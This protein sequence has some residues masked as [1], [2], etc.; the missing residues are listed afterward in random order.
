MDRKPLSDARASA[1]GILAVSFVITVISFFS[2]YWLVAD[3]RY[4]G[5]EFDKLGLWTVC[6]RS[7]RGP[8][9]LEYTKYYS[10]CRWIY[11]YE[12]RNIRNF[13]LPRSY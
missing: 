6:F 1:I 13:L 5:A 7:F 4:Y 2:P 9:D 10:G 8:N 12:Y 3:R 11:F